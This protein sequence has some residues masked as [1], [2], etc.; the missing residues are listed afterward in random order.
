MKFIETDLETV[1]SHFDNLSAD[2]KPKW[3]TMSAQQMVE[4]LTHTLEI[5]MGMHQY[6]PLIKAEDY[7]KMRMFINSDKALPRNFKVEFAS[8]NPPLIHEEIE[9]AI[10][11]YCDAWL[12]FETLFAENPTLETMHPNFGMLNY[13]LWNRLHSKHLTHHFI[14]FGLI[15]E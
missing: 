13:E 7:D 8:E 6:T 9:L 11:T 3:G 5:A 12:E 1:L 15:V 14:Q 2:T 10:D 4:H